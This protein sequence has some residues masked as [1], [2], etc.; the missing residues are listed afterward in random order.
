MAASLER[1]LGVPAWTT[2]LDPLMATEERLF[3]SFL[4]ALTNATAHP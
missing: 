3:G 1:V 4:D 2:R